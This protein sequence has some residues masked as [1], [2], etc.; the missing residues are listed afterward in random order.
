MEEGQPEVALGQVNP[1]TGA[2]DLGASQVDFSVEIYD[3]SRNMWVRMCTSKSRPD[4][5]ASH[6]EASQVETSPDFVPFSLQQLGELKEISS[7]KFN[8]IDFT[9]YTMDVIDALFP[10]RA[11][12]GQLDPPAS[13][14][15]SPKRL[16]EWRRQTPRSQICLTS[17][18]SSPGD[19]TTAETSPD[20]VRFSLDQL[21]ELKETCSSQFNTLDFSDY[22]LNVI[23]ALF[24]KKPINGKLDPP[25][26]Y[27]TSPKR[28]REWR[29]QTTKSQQYLMDKEQET[30]QKQPPADTVP[31]TTG[32]AI[33][34]TRSQRNSDATTKKAQ[35]KRPMPQQG[36][37][38]PSKSES[39]KR[40]K[41]GLYPS[42]E[43]SSVASLLLD[44]RSKK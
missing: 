41:N 39:E 9:G 38:V 4:S 22:T 33:R 26:S 36:A 44:I 14:R 17:A 40:A 8:A 28:L 5:N 21:Q 2:S 24:P 42:L 1:W 30:V 19:S 10:K 15:T 16:R 3:M 13:Y 12:G 32:R 29:R 18:Q 11:F 25:A 43:A 35:L 6:L 7:K 34:T 20:F 23:D 31:T 37:D 27:R